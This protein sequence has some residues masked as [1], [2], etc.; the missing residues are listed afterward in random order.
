MKE[1]LLAHKDGILPRG[2]FLPALLDVAT[3]NAFSRE[4]LPGRCSIDELGAIITRTAIEFSTMALHNP[5]Q[6]ATVHMG[7]VMSKVR[8]R[9]EGSIVAQAM[10]YTSREARP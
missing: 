2:G 5:E 3:G 4:S 7:A 10:N 6:A 1:I 8:R 9:I